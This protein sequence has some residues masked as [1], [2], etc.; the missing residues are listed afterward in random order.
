MPIT[1]FLRMHWLLSKIQ[2]HLTIWRK[3][4]YRDCKEASSFQEP[5][6]RRH[7]CADSKGFGQDIKTAEHEQQQRKYVIIDLSK[8]YRVC[9]DISCAL[10][11]TMTCWCRFMDSNGETYG[12]G[13]GSGSTWWRYEEA[14]NALCW[15]SNFSIT[16]ILLKNGLFFK[17]IKRRH[18]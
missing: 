16:L 11:L 10:H 3:Q 8:M 5:R 7:L 17:K 12:R 2:L 4:N 9:F 14:G 15:W 6:E 18:W 1:A 13:V